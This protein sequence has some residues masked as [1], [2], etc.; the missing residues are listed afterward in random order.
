MKENS[1]CVIVSMAQLRN[2]FIT[3]NNYSP[4]EEKL[5]QEWEVSYISYGC[6]E[7]PSTGTPHLHAYV[8]FKHPV[9][10]TTLKKKLPRADIEKRKGTAQQASD[11][12]V[13]EGVTFTKGQISKQ[14]NRSDL[15]AVVEAVKSGKRTREIAREH[16]IQFIKFH[17]GIEKL[18]T[19][20][21]EPRNEDNPK[22]IEVFWGP[23]G[24][25]K[26]R[27]ARE[28]L[29]R[30]DL[31]I[32]N[33]GMEKWFD[34]YEGEKNVIFEEFRGQ[35]TLGNLLIV[36]DRYNCRQQNKGGSVNFCPDHIIFTSPK[37]P[38]EWYNEYDDKDRYDQ[39]QRRLTNVTHFSDVFSK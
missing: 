21:I 34:G 23:T 2:A 10:F 32:W 9:K 17:R 31:W 33:P 18:I 25:G 19:H 26:S 30:D 24:T 6:E 39:L 36:T 12:A 16:P 38:K 14:G 22:R 29:D 13:K 37:H 3:I 5:L 35:M 20:F 8:E 11:Y 7:A 28:A 15:D 4:E 27:K 1:E